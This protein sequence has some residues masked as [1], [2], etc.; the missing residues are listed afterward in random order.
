MLRTSSAIEKANFVES[1]IFEFKFCSLSKCRDVPDVSVRIL[2]ARAALLVGLV[3]WL[4][5]RSGACRD[6]TLRR[7]V[8]VL[9]IYVNRRLSSARMR[10]FADFQHDYRVANFRLDVKPMV[11][12]R[13]AFQFLGAESLLQQVWQIEA[14]VEIGADTADTV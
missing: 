7:R 14:P 1:E 9:H 11:A 13:E 10:R 12:D 2:D 3:R 6:R 8:N 4:G 5:N